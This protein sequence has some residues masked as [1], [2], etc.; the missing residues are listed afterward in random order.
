MSTHSL[1]SRV[2]GLILRGKATALEDQRQKCLS[3]SVPT[4]PMAALLTRLWDGLVGE[5]RSQASLLL[6]G[7]WKGR[8]WSE[9]GVGKGSGQA[10]EL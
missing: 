6:P 10:K 8:K 2:S 4:W 3:S 5:G 9:K 1:S 7:R